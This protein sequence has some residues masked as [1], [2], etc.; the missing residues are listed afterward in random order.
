MCVFRFTVQDGRHPP[1]LV[2]V[3]FFTVHWTLIFRERHGLSDRRLVWIWTNRLSSR[4][5][6]QVVETKVIL[7]FILFDIDTESEGLFSE[8]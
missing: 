1:T 5:F 2:G 3:C 6:C 8:R 7:G 4:G